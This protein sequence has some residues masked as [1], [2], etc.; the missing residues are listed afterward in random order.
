MFFNLIQ[1]RFDLLFLAQ[2]AQFGTFVNPRMA[3]LTRGSG[4]VEK[5]PWHSA[6]GY[7]PLVAVLRLKSK[8]IRSTSL[9]AHYR[10]IVSEPFLSA[11]GDSIDRAI[12]ECRSKENS[13]TDSPVI[14]GMEF[15][16]SMCPV[17]A[18][19]SEPEKSY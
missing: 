10:G 13:S 8:P 1:W 19:A 16:S 7:C 17:P 3:T 2:S 5:K 18:G 14:C 6:R 9:S 12:I 4:E 11:S 15:L